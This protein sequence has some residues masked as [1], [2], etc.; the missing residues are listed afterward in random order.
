MNE[1]ATEND[2]ERKRK[3]DKNIGA[4]YFK[5]P[6]IFIVLAAVQGWIHKFELDSKFYRIIVTTVK[7]EIL[8][9][10]YYIISRVLF[11]TK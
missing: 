11:E 6:S 9:K 10:V 1:P 3:R 4:T 2:D 5:F 8:S 7:T